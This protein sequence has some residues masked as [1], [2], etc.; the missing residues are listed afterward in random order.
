MFKIHLRPDFSTPRILF[1]YKHVNWHL[2]RSSLDLALDLHPII[3]NAVELDNATATFSQAVQQAANQ[4]IPLHTARRNLL[5]LPPSI[6]YLWKLK[7]YYWRRHQRTRSPLLCHIYHIFARVF[8]LHFTRLR[9]SKWSLFLQSLEP[10]SSQFWKIARYFTKSP[11]AIPPPDASK[12]K[13]LLHPAQSRSFSATV[14]TLPSPYPHF[15]HAASLFN[16]PP[17]RRQILQ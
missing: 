11:L 6:H 16:G 8:S 17:I 4:A 5:T 10:Q 9:N 14:R 7:N 1:D 15:G 12:Y 2:F 3:Q 13:S